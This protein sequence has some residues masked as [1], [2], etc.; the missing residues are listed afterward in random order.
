MTF[1]RA[2]REVR[3]PWCLKLFTS[4]VHS[5]GPGGPHLVLKGAQTSGSPPFL[6]HLGPLMFLLVKSRK[7]CSWKSHQPWLR[8]RSSVIPQE[9]K[10]EKGKKSMFVCAHTCHHMYHPYH[11][12]HI[13]ALA[14]FTHRFSYMHIFVDLHTRVFT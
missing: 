8:F 7:P 4:L 13:W 10:K 2:H 9:E 11:T 12:Y 5:S 14:H 1:P 3:G 6:T